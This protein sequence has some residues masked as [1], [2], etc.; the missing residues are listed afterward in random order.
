M[1]FG[2][3]RKRRESG[4]TK[5]PSFRASNVRLVLIAILLACLISANH[6]YAECVTDSVGR[7]WCSRYKGGGIGIDSIGIIKCAG[8]C[9][10]ASLSRAMLTG[11]GSKMPSNGIFPIGDQAETV[12]RTRDARV[13]T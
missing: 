3:S 5:S 11:T 7:V 4:D 1:R 12:S 8:G 6:I 13:K 2:L 9:E 10:E